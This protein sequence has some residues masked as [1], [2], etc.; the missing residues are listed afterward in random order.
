MRRLLN[1]PVLAFCLAGLG[2]AA[3]A[4]LGMRPGPE[5]SALAFWLYA[6]AGVLG[7]LLSGAVLVLS[8]RST[9]PFPRGGRFE[10]T[11]ALMACI[12]VLLLGSA[13]YGLLA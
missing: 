7:L 13:L 11:Y 1:L 8:G 12:A 4:A 3:H 6:A 5:S 9:P 10:A 2:L